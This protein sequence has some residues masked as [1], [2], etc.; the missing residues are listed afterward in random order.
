M[1]HTKITILPEKDNADGTRGKFIGILVMGISF[2]IVPLVAVSG[3]FIFIHANRNTEVETRS[4]NADSSKEAALSNGM[5]ELHQDTR[6]INASSPVELRDVSDIYESAS[7]SVVSIGIPRQGIIGSGFIVDATGII[8][9]NYHVVSFTNASYFVQLQDGNR[10]EVQSVTRRPEND[11]ALLRVNAS[12][13]PALPLSTTQ[14]RPGQ[15]VVA[16]G[17]PLGSLE[18][19]ITSGI[20]SGVNRE[21]VIE[22]STFRGVSIRFPDAIQTD[23]AVN[24][25]NSGGPLLNSEGEVVGVNFAGVRGV[26]NI[27]F[28]I[29]AEY[30]QEFITELRE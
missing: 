21:V 23:A 30:L 8:A 13:L 3:F 19:T 28:A 14:I 6:Q 1:V 16:I 29:P 17:N 26:E 2:F 27:A 4:E 10:Y 11:L 25:G 20:I 22:P 15:A 7:P 9:T 24:P 18:S 12:N 5:H